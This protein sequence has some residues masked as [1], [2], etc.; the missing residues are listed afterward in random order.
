MAGLR[1]RRGPKRGSSESISAAQM[2]IPATRLPL[3]SV[4]RQNFSAIEMAP[5]I[6]LPT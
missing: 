5:A 4:L 1:V 6:E 3:L 2:F